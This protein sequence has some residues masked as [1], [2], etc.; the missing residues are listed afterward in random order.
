MLYT[1]AHLQQGKSKG[2]KE[3]SEEAKPPPFAP[4]HRLAR[5]P[6]EEEGNEKMKERM[7]VLNAQ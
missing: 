2:K 7:A 4:S 6:R 5:T 1:H 3:S